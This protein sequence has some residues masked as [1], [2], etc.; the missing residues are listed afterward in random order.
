MFGKNFAEISIRVLSLVILLVSASFLASAQAIVQND[1]EDGTTQNWI[2]R[3]GTVSL[4]NTTE[5]AATGSRSLKTTGRTAGFNGPSLNVLSL[6]SPGVVYQVTASVR[7]VSGETPTTLKITVQRTPTGGSNAFDQVTPSTN[8]TD[9]SW[10]TLTGQYSFAGSVS[11]LLLYVESASATASF[12]VDDFKI[13][14]VPAI[15]CAD[16]PDTSG[17]HT[18]FETGTAQGW[19]PRIGRETVA[20]TNADAHFGTF[21]LLTT[22][23]QATFDGPS[24]NAAGKLCN[25]SR[26]NISVWVKLAPGQ[27]TSQLRLSLQRTLAGTTN[28]NTVVGNTAVT[29]DQ[30]VRLKTTFDF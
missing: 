28:F 5:A 25:G 18:N 2:P 27:P 4:T 11:G 3:G 9:S 24:I 16:P 12:Y 19:V 8:V 10:V 6:L 1:F 22:G 17:I 15:G 20:V 7:L 26:Y 29:A 13:T 30:W 23:R 21:S 14:V